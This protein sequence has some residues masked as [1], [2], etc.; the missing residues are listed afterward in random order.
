MSCSFA[1]VPRRLRAHPGEVQ[2]EVR[3]QAGAR[4]L[5]PDARLRL[6]HHQGADPALAKVPRI[7]QVDNTTYGKK[8]LIRLSVGHQAMFRG[9]I[10]RTKY[11]CFQVFI[12]P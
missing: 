8:L 9:D 11:F 5:R 10:S 6:H 4:P 1:V 3:L 2:G 12:I 7:H